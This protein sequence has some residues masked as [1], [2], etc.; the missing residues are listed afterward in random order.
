MQRLSL[1]EIVPACNLS[2]Y[3]EIYYFTLRG[4]RTATESEI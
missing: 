2:L 3:R 4:L 1:F